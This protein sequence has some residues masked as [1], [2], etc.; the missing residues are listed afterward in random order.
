MKNIIH[1]NILAL[2]LLILI[3]VPQILL[4]QAAAIPNEAAYQKME[5]QFEAPEVSSEQ[6]FLFEKKGIQHLKDFMNVVEML[7]ADDVDPKFRSKL[8]MA[9]AKYFSSPT[10]SLTLTFD[11]KTTPITVESFLDK[12][13]KGE[14]KFQ[15]IKLSNFKS[16]TP[17]FLEKKYKWE[18]SFLFSPNGNEEKNMIAI[19][20]LNKEKKKFGSV[21]KEVWEVLLEKIKEEK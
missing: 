2:A 19:F 17:V 20:I 7:S 18:V 10:D 15:T 3:F 1:V 14:S 16:T 5:Q 6:L 8:K 13:E 11:K 12:L 9:A 4:S 21:E